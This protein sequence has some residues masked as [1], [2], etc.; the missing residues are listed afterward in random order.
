[1]F[2]SD[3]TRVFLVGCPRSGTTVIQSDFAKY[4]PFYTFPETGFLLDGLETFPARSKALYR[5]QSIYESRD[6]PPYGVWYKFK[7]FQELC[8]YWAPKLGMHSF[9]KHLSSPDSCLHLWI[10]H[11]DALALDSGYAGWIEKTPRHFYQLRYIQKI[12]PSPH[13]FFV[14]RNGQDV[15]ASIVDRSLNSQQWFCS[16]GIDFAIN[17]WNESV[18]L[19]ADLSLL[20]QVHC[21]SFENYLYD[22]FGM[23]EMIKTV[24]STELCSGSVLPVFCKSNE[25]WKRGSFGSL[26]YPE[27]KKSKLFTR[28]TLHYINSRLDWESYKK[29][30]YLGQG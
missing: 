16:E 15:V 28:E 30:R 9:L 23:R 17:I 29:I 12:T 8:L 21:I 5:L 1:M 11:L 10:N 18:R 14:V 24:L 26:S 25:Y 7:K 19:A 27:D 22:P 20:G 2:R 13:I 4:F 3:I 6:M